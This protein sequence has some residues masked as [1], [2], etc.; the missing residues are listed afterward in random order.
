[1][2]TMIGRL[3]SLWS[4]A[5]AS[6]APPKRVWR[7]WLLVTVFPVLIVVEGLLRT[8]LTNRVPSIVVAIAVV[9]TLLWRRTHPL[10]MFAI[11]FGV[12]EGFA[13]VTGH[14]LQLYSSAYL[15]VLVYAVFRWGSGRALVIGGALMLAST[16][17]STV[18]VPFEVADLIGGL[19]F[20]LVT[21]TL[22]LLMR[23]RA[24]ARMRD[25]D[26]AK[27]EEREELARDLH[28]TV[29]HHVSAIAIQAQAGLAT[30]GTNP[31][32]ATA[33]LR[34]IEAEA[35]RTL[36][37][38]RAMVRVLR[39]DKA[40][41]L[42]P[43]AHIA[44]LHQ[45]ARAADPVID[46]QVTGDVDSLAAPIA[47]AVFRIAQE[48]VTNARRHA[49]TLS[50][51]DMRVDVDDSRVR[52][53]VHDDGAAGPTGEPGYGITGMTERAALLGGTCTAGR[54]ADGGWTVTAELP[55]TGV[56]A[57]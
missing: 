14:D 46:V 40:A 48:S 10:L 39:R 35:S 57:A 33:A 34:V 7:D 32:A 55:R 2:S 53:S 22:G 27:S 24:S 4:I 42:A 45:L 30:V 20:L 25:R 17:V 37:E 44:D 12:T 51:I 8:D 21:A 50:R 19:L 28:D 38:M 16:F 29:A 11:G 13:L 43:A 18:R 26:R 41:E 36:T 31:D 54:S 49:R 9:A 56:A 23:F 3:R 5:P 15:L 52:L 47:S 1:M 6:P